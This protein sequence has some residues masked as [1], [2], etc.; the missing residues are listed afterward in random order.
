MNPNDHFVYPFEENRGPL[1]IQSLVES[2]DDSTNSS[3]FTY[4]NIDAARLGQLLTKCRQVNAKLTGLLN[5]ICSMATYRTYQAYDCA[6]MS[7]TICYHYLANM[8]PMLSLG[9]LN[10]GYF[11]VVFNGVFSTEPIK[12]GPSSEAFWKLAKAESD[13]I[14][15]RMSDSELLENAKLDVTLLEL[16]DQEFVFEN[17]SVHF[18]LSNLGPLE[19]ASPVFTVKGFYYNTSTVVNRWAAVVFHGLSSVNNTL[20]WS[21]GYNASLV[22]DD[23]V[24]TL[25]AH[26][27]K[28]V[29]EIL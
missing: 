17:G 14:H 4:F 19:S 21:L 6:E 5:L 22:R 27:N 20:C 24:Q 26:I 15:E 13:L 25:V 18:A 11:P 9:N 7:E 10:M 23:V 2:R 28:I 8:R 1:L 12:E 16:I 3:K 29:E